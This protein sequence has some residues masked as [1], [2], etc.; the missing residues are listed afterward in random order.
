MGKQRHG[1]RRKDT[2]KKAR[3]QSHNAHNVAHSPTQGKKI[4]NALFKFLVDCKQR[5][6]SRHQPKTLTE[7]IEKYKKLPFF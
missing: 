4:E 7:P 3:Q 2:Q 6:K 5:D 1:Y